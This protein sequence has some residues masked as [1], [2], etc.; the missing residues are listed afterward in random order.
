YGTNTISFTLPS[1]EVATPRSYA[2]FQ[3]AID[4]NGQSRIYLGVHWQFDN[5]RGKT[6]GQQIAD[7]IWPNFL[8]PIG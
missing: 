7:Y 4:E 5:T 2:T 1:D 3:A 6:L 8:R